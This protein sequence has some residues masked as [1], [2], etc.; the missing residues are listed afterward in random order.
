MS[1][2]INANVLGLCEV[3]GFCPW[4][5][6]ILD[7]NSFVV[8]LGSFRGDFSKYIYETYNCRV[9]AYDPLGIHIG[10]EHPKFKFIRAAVLDGSIVTFEKSG[11][12]SNIMN[13]T[14]V[15]MRSVD[16]RGIT[17]EHINLMKVNIEGA[18]ITVLQLACLDN[19]DQL[20]VEFH[21][22][23]YSA[24]NFEFIKKEIE[25]VVE[26]IMSFDFKMKQINS[27]PAYFFYK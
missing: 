23:R 11:T 22:F 25:K 17:K 1:K 9:D 2:S 26:R 20:L 24:P 7:E 12:A 6:F 21:L 16:I 10:V 19:I 5:H 14:G 27:A 8:D 15:Q 13:N 4:E 3:D 18:E